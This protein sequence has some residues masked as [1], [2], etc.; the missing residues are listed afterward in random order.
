MDYNC[1]ASLF[2]IGM[3]SNFLAALF[4]C[5]MLSLVACVYFGLGDNNIN[6]AIESDLLLY[7]T[8]S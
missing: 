6:N 7:F 3:F 8:L 1:P 4:P 2:L 5:V